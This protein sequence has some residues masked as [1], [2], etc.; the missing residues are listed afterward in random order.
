M[1][2]VFSLLIAA[3][4]MCSL[5]AGGALTAKA[6]SSNALEL[7]AEALGEDQVLL[8]IKVT[9]PL[10]IGYIRAKLEFSDAFTYA[11][12]NSPFSNSNYNQNN[13]LFNASD[14]Y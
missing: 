1:K 9:E 8:K 6:E 14:D 13:N 3:I 10:T 2:R 12:K 7:T 5:F 4:L 11:G